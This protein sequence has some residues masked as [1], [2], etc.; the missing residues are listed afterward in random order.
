M[1]KLIFLYGLCVLS[2]LL[3]EQKSNFD[4]LLKRILIVLC[5][6][7]AQ[8][9]LSIQILSLN[10]WLH[11]W[12]LLG[13]NVLLS[14]LLYLVL[15][16][17]K[18]TEPRQSWKTLVISAVGEIKAIST[19][20]ALLLS[21]LSTVSFVILLW[22]IGVSVMPFGDVYHYDM[23][24][25]WRQNQSILPFP[26]P[27]PRVVAVSFASEAISL[28]GYIYVQSDK[29]TAVLA[30]L[31][32][33]L[34][35]WLVYALARRLGCSQVASASA[36]L[37]TTGYNVYALAFLTM[38]ADIYFAMLLSGASLLFLLD[39]CHP[40]ERLRLH[41][42]SWAIFCFVMAC[43]AKN[44]CTLAAPFFI[45]CIIIVLSC[46][47]RKMKSL[48]RL[49][50]VGALGL[51]CSGVFWNFTS[52]QLWFGNIKGPQFMQEH[53]SKD[54][55]L[56]SIWTREARGAV[57]F[58]LDTTWIPKSLESRYVDLWST[59]LHMLGASETIP[60]D[61]L[62]FDLQ[63]KNM[64]PR[65][66]LGL[67]GICFF[68][69]G[70]IVGMARCSGIRRRRPAEENS[71]RLKTG[72]LVIITIGSFVVTHIILRWHNIGL[73]RI[74]PVFLIAGAPLAAPLFEKKP[75]RNTGLILLGISLAMVL[76]YNF[77]AFQY[78]SC[79][80]A[81]PT[82]QKLANI[83]ND[84]DLT[85][86]YAWR[87]QNLRKVSM[88]DDNFAQNFYGAFLSGISPTV[89]GVIGGHDASMFYLFGEG[90]SNRIV[91]LIDMRSYDQLL[92]PENGIIRS[93][94]RLLE[95]G[96]N[97]YDQLLEPENDIE[98]IV[99]SEIGVG[100]DYWVF[101][102]TQVDE[103]SRKHKFYPIF[104]ATNGDKHFFTAYK[105]DSGPI[106]HFVK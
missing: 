63:K 36:A 75:L 98:Y 103:W 21:F 54:F 5:I 57:M 64:R 22:G 26:V 71:Q 19:E 29:I 37:L 65:N 1:I 14:T 58:L 77:G 27:N 55:Q 68:L 66:G 43:G 4:S 28:P 8:L 51:V 42:L 95:P 85:I 88:V 12:G 38:A 33:L 99:F 67:L 15:Y 44:S 83:R 41:N 78:W 105:K 2:G 23:P 30:I 100:P 50:V 32:A 106:S 87:E 11:G 45:F 56:R 89:I 47:T 7:A 96:N 49:I 3:L 93:Y 34:C 61:G 97:I 53:T 90:F 101:N 94:G 40:D 102:S 79:Y 69:P 20:R 6:G 91:P 104:R 18:E 92:E 80:K 24:L 17:R 9:I 13:A 60:E 52:N 86:E 74:M 59:C 76:K 72:L 81:S 62:Y 25:F 35:I 48:S 16:H 82:L 46:S 73:F 70:V 84:N 10:Y 31:A 39:A